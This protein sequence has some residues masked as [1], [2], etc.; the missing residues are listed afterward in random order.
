MPEE[1]NPK[2]QWITAEKIVQLG[3]ALP[4]ATVI[5]WAIG[6]GLDN[7]LH[8][9]WLSLAGLIMGIAAGFVHFVRVAVAAMDEKDQR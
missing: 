8:T 3:I 2:K 1:Q 9:R 7:W 5:G 4:A 6:S